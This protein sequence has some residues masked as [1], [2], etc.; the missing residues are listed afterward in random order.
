LFFEILIP[1]CSAQSILISHK[2][3]YSSRE[4]DFKDHKFLEK[5]VLDTVEN[6]SENFFNGLLSVSFEDRV[7][8]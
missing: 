6:E 1:R 2:F 7:E 4:V 5:L 3:I 8:Y